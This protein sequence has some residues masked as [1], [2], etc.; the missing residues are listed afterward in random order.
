MQCGLL[1]EHYYKPATHELGWADFQV[2]SEQAIVRHWQ[3]VMLAFTF[4]LLTATPSDQAEQAPRGDGGAAGGKSAPPDHLA[5]HP[6]PGPRLAV[7]L[8][9]PAAVLAPLV[10]RPTPTRTGSPA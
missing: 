9:A 1:F 3:L 10:H 6:A 2:R 8:G 7:S 5:G 4:T